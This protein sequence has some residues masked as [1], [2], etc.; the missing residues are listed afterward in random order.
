MGIWLSFEREQGKDCWRDMSIRHVN[1][2]ER[3]TL[4]PC[5][6]WAHLHVVNFWVWA[7][8]RIGKLLGADRVFNGN[9]R[10]EGPDSTILSCS[11]KLQKLDLKIKVGSMCGGDDTYGRFV[12][13]KRQGNCSINLRATVVICERAIQIFLF[14]QRFSQSSVD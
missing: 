5:T 6:H 2:A 11:F 7:C 12:F 10:V 4:Q 8:H 1:K 9:R 14:L 13:A 3:P